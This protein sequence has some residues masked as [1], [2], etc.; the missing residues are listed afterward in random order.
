MKLE[1]P[2]LLKRRQK[3]LIDPG[4]Q[5]RAGAYVVVW[6]LGLAIIAPVA[7]MSVFDLVM[8]QPGQNLQELEAT[9]TQF[10]WV[11][12]VF[13]V[14]YLLLAFALTVVSFSHRVVGPI[15][16]LKNVFLRAAQG[17]WPNQIQFRKPDEFK[18]LAEGYN[19]LSQAR[20][21]ERNH[22]VQSVS[23]VIARVES[24]SHEEVKEAVAE[25]KQ[26]REELSRS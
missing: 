18:D 22:F 2:N 8:Q 24:G 12:G 6:I 1:L 16:N 14:G 7:L 17:D 26:L 3:I 21:D 20:R 10:L 5:V 23:T 15:F 19:V 4:F 13:Q 9:R 25:L 11:F